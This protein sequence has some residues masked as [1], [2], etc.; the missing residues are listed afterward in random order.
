MTWNPLDCY[1][2]ALEKLDYGSTQVSF[3]IKMNY[4]PQDLYFFRSIEECGLV[5][6]PGST[7]YDLV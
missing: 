4:C 5:Q 2:S 3:R 6:I 7:T 1:R